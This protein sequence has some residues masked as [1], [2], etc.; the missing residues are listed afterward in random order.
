[1]EVSSMGVLPINLVAYLFKA[2]L[3][4]SVSV[5]ILTLIDLLNKE[6]YQPNLCL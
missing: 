1:M 2:F 4:T 6:L 3:D 5:F